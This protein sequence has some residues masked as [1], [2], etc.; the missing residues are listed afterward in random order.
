MFNRNKIFSFQIT[1][2]AKNVFRVKKK[3]TYICK[4]IV[5]RVKFM[6]QV[7]ADE[8]LFLPRMD[9]NQCPAIFITHIL[10]EQGPGGGIRFLQISEQYVAFMQ[11]RRTN[12]KTKKHLLLK[13]NPSGHTTLNDVVSTSM[14]RDHVASTLIRRHFDV[15]CLL[16]YSRLSLSRIPRNSLKYFDISVPQHIRFAELRKN[17]SHNH[18]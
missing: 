1:R 18:I 3:L 10:L 4:G 8:V 2:R 17:N 14:R 15:M 11:I 12:W 7:I 6:K 13:H 9:V 5:G 16:G